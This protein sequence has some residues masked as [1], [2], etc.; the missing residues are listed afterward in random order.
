MW[1]KPD[2]K[3]RQQTTTQTRNTQTQTNTNTSTT[4][5]TAPQPKTLKT[6]HNHSHSH[7]TTTTP[8]SVHPQSPEPPLQGDSPP[9]KTTRRRRDIR[10]RPRVPLAFHVQVEGVQVA[11]VVDGGLQ[12]RVACNQGRKRIVHSSRPST[13]PAT[14]EALT[15]PALPCTCRR[16]SSTREVS[17]HQRRPVAEP[18]PRT[19]S[20]AASEAP[21]PRHTQD[22]ESSPSLHRQSV[23]TW[24]AGIIEWR[25]A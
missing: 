19:A 25:G 11:V 3:R 22:P 24:G 15:R 1:T 20:R 6:P 7:R 12:P 16:E 18:L 13:G 23:A 17:S 9:A 10:A 21:T 2:N 5:T 8:P 4:K 14:V